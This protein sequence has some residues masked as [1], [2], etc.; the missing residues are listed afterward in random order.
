MWCVMM[1]MPN[2]V[3]VT[4]LNI[5]SSAIYFFLMVLWK[6]LQFVYIVHYYYHLFGDGS[7]I[8][9]KGNSKWYLN[10]TCLVIS[11]YSETF[12][13]LLWFIDSV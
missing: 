9:N 3:P 13:D 11:M 4:Y 5:N 1:Y 10:S 2:Y 6:L 7:V 8:S 12:F